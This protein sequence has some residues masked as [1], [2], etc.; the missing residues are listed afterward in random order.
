MLVIGSMEHVR[1]ANIIKMKGRDGE[2]VFITFPTEEV[3]QATCNPIASG[4]FPQ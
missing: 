2:E 1:K 4:S 3:N